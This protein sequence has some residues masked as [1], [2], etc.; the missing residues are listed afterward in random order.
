MDNNEEI[1]QAFN[2]LYLLARKAQV[3]AENG[4]VREKCARILHEAIKDK[5]PVE[6]DKES[7]A[8]KRKKK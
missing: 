6:D 4:D 8:A 2:T 7:S 3:D 5:F 1:H